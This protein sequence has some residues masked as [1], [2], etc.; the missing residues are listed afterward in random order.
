MSQ[1]PQVIVDEPLNAGMGAPETTEKKP[2]AG[3]YRALAI[4]SFLIAAGGLFLGLLYQV[5]G[6]FKPYFVGEDFLPN[7]LLGYVYTYYKGMFADIGT[8][9]HDLFTLGDIL[10]LT[11]FVCIILLSV[12]VVLSLVLMII[13]FFTAKGAKNCAMTSAVLVF[14]A[15][16]GLFIIPYYLYA[17]TNNRFGGGMLDVTTGIPAAVMLIALAVTAIARRKGLGLLNLISFLLVGAVLFGLAYPGTETLSVYVNYMHLTDGSLFV[18]LTALITA[19][20]IALELVISTIRL[21]AK[22]A[23]IF[24]TVRYGVLLIVVI[25]S[26]CALI[27]D[28]TFDVMF[29][30]ANLLPVIVVVASSLVA[31]LLALVIAIVQASKARA[32][33]AEK[34][35]AE[36][37]ERYALSQPA[38]VPAPATL[39]TTPVPAAEQLSATAPTAAPAPAPVPAPASAPAAEAQPAAQTQTQAAPGTTVIIQQPSA[40]QHPATPIYAVPFFAAPMSP[41]AQQSAVTAAPASEPA[42]A[43]AP[44]PESAPAE[45]TPMSEFERSMAALAR[46][47]AP[48]PAP[49]P[50]AQ[51]AAGVTYQYTPAPAPTTPVYSAPYQAPQ[52]AYRQPSAAPKMVYDPTPYTYDAYINTLTPQEKNEFCDMFIANRFGDL[53]YLPV[54]VIG[55]DNREFFRKVFI[56]LGKFRSH[57]SPALLGKLY[58]YVSKM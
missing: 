15:Y 5:S 25:L 35:S 28:R 46:G 20:V 4:I 22:K 47:I 32:K 34:T 16:A 36:I 10:E 30:S 3:G 6:I 51:T 31:F 8:F 33:E 19:I 39:Q 14:L 57:I 54:Y 50:A 45:D 48:E 49:A 12:A 24:D 21:S 58:D 52:M 53:A 2:A 56:Y 27:V 7:S 37:G 1:F 13:S 26:V 9:F 43:P 11:L 41:A 40:T 17:F 18:N 44:A 55:G 29:G 23:Y 38:A 42:P